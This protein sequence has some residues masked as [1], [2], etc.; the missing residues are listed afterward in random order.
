[1]KKYIFICLLV[2]L[3]FLSGCF[4]PDAERPGQTSDSDE[5]SICSH[6]YCSGVTG[7]TADEACGEGY[8]NYGKGLCDCYASEYWCARLD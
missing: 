1:M 7:M 5:D 2:L 8:I 6:G 3:L 4:F